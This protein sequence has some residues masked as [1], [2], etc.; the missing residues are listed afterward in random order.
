M[1]R[2]Y[3]RNGESVPCFNL[4]RAIR[5]L[6]LALKSALALDDRRRVK[7]LAKV[8]PL[9]VLVPQHRCRITADEDSSGEHNV[10]A[11]GDR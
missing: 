10:A 2:T 11:V 1:G 6:L 8:E 9:C 5:V 3:R 7:P 4:R